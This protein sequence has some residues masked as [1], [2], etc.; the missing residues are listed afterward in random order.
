MSSNRYHFT[1][2]ELLVSISIIAILAALILPGLSESKERARFTRWLQFNKQCCADPACVVNLNFQEGEGEILKNSALGC[3]AEGFNAEDYNGIIKGNCEWVNGRW[4]KGKKALQFDG[5]STYVEL[6]KFK[7]INFDI[8]DDFTIITWVKF[9]RLRQFDGVFSKSYWASNGYAQYDLYFDGTSYND[10]EASG[11]FEVDVC[12]TCLGF[13]DVTEDGGKNITLNKEDWFQ[14]VLRYNTKD[15]VHEVSV[16]VN[17]LK[18]KPRNSNFL[19]STKT[20]CDARLAIGCIRWM[21]GDNK[22]GRL[23]NFLQGRIDEFL[24]YKRALTDNEIKGHY[25]MGAQHL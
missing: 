14:L 8:N 12:S 23:K 18:L 19:S 5:I 15:G 22:D 4:N 11:Q 9:D 1:V 6:L 21:N 2:I 24:V 17:G 25:E 3:E 16:F 13:D 20:I 10:H 7:N